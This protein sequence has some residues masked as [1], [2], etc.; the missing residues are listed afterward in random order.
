MSL[1]YN[2]YKESSGRGNEQNKSS[3]A[4]YC[5]KDS[6]KIGCNTAL[7]E[8]LAELCQLH[9]VVHGRVELLG[10]ERDGPARDHRKA[11]LEGVGVIEKRRQSISGDQHSV[12]RV[13]IVEVLEWAVNDNALV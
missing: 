2:V 10:V 3:L 7:H 11:P 8:V 6:R 5:A 9:W 12:V 4:P 1:Q 13:G